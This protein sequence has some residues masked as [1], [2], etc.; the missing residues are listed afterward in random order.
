MQNYINQLIEDLEDA[1]KAEIQQA[2]IKTPPHLAD[3]PEMAELALVPF[4]PICEWIEISKDVFPEMWQLTYEQCVQLNKA[5]FKVFDNL[6]LSLVDKPKD[7]PEDWLYEVLISNWDYPVQ[8]LPST[9]MDLEL[10]SGDWKT[11]DYGKYC[12]CAQNNYDNIDDNEPTINLTDN[13]N[14]N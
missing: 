14:T 11:C 3:N 8:Y 9:G 2:N 1:A 12:H 6:N 5:I 4:K 10:C 13:E 7:I